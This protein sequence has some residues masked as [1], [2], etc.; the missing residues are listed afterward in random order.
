VKE[1]TEE[2]TLINKSTLKNRIEEGKI[3]LGRRGRTVASTEGTHA[4]TLRE[5]RQG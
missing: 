2:R 3:A 1:K 5:E 4:S